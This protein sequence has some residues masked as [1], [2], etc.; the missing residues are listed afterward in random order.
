METERTE[1]P[2]EASMSPRNTVRKHSAKSSPATDEPDLRKLSADLVA[3]VGNLRVSGLALPASRLY[4]AVRE[5]DDERDPLVVAW[6]AEACIEAFLVEAKGA[7]GK[8]GNGA[9]DILDGS[10]LLR[11]QL[12]WLGRLVDVAEREA[13]ASVAKDLARTTASRPA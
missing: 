3:L 2:E 5:P 8:Q 13:H 9:R 1:G 4:S 10:R 7:L 11:H 6:A 12:R